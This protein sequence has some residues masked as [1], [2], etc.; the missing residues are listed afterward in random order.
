MMLPCFLPRYF[1]QIV[2]SARANGTAGPTEDHTDD[3][4]GCL[5]IPVR[6]CVV[7]M[8]WLQLGSSGC[9]LGSPQA[10]YLPWAS[11]KEATPSYLLCL[12][13]MNALSLPPECTG[14]CMEG[15]VGNPLGLTLLH[16]TL[17]QEVPVAGADRWFKLEPRSSASRVQGDCHLVLKLITTQVGS[18]L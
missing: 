9:I 18:L 14:M 10:S 1:K 3:F 15:E 8:G 6:V 5:N 13:P 17:P 11:G 16:L 2:K 4:L 12:G 7:E